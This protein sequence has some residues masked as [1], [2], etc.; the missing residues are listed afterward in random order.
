MAFQNPGVDFRFWATG[1]QHHPSR[2]D[3]QNGACIP[4]GV[5]V[6]RQVRSGSPPGPSMSLSK[7]SSSWSSGKSDPG[8][9]PGAPALRHRH[10]VVGDLVGERGHDRGALGG[11]E[12]LPLLGAR[13]HR[14]PGRTSAHCDHASTAWRPG[15]LGSSPPS[16]WARRFEVRA[17]RR[18]SH[19]AHA[20]EARLVP[21]AILARCKA[22]ELAAPSLVWSDL[23]TFCDFAA[24][25][26]LR[27][28]FGREL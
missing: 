16:A 14:K 19:A 9:P 24:L 20:V 7:A 10:L 22:I 4:L 1:E 13:R 23:L 27:V 17:H 6:E 18:P 28:R 3:M 2:R 8:S 12:C 26:L 5:H 11:R 21:K 15:A 25:P